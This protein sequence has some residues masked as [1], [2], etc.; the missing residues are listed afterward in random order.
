MHW[1]YVMS[2]HVILQSALKNARIP[3]YLV[4]FKLSNS[5]VVLLSGWRREYWK[6]H[7]KAE[8]CI[9]DTARSPSNAFH[10]MQ[11]EAK[12]ILVQNYS[13]NVAPAKCET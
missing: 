7:A 6:M 11:Y 4:K 5:N 8:S 3:G 13:K 12:H 1:I 9:A 2:L 10:P